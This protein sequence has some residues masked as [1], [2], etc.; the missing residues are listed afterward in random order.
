MIYTSEGQ[1]K[2]NRYHKEAE[3]YRML[4]KGN[5]RRGAAERLRALAERLEAPTL[6]PLPKGAPRVG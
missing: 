3:L 1:D 5:W 6:E 2:L 4:P